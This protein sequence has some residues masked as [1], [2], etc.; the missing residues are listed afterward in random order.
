MVTDSYS[1]FVGNFI[2][3]VG[4]MSDFCRLN[5]PIM[6]I[7]INQCCRLRKRVRT[8]KSSFWWKTSIIFPWNP[9]IFPFHKHWTPAAMNEIFRMPHW[10]PSNLW[11][12]IPSGPRSP[13]AVSFAAAAAAAL[14]KRGKKAA[15]STEVPRGAGWCGD[16]SFHPPTAGK[17]IEAY[18]AIWV[19]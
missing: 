18:F 4:K 12:L 11:I 6:T 5:I 10:W 15:P 13:C 19:W 3:F 17:K 8:P 14:V 2:I 1:G 16:A 9:T 7:T